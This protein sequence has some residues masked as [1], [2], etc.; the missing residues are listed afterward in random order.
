MRSKKPGSHAPGPSRYVYPGQVNSVALNSRAKITQAMDETRQ[1][2]RE[3]KTD[4]EEHDVA[5][6]LEALRDERRRHEQIIQKDK[7][8][9]LENKRAA[10]FMRMGGQ[11]PPPPL[12]EL[13]SLFDSD[14][15][16]ADE[17]VIV[18]KSAADCDVAGKPRK[19]KLL[20]RKP[21][22]RLDSRDKRTASEFD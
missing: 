6:T 20:L 22:F 4:E 3:A 14:V 17:G 16:E 12:G 18:V 7:K 2:S 9:R 5:L 8:T 13:G 21:G 15:T 10:R 1:K 19:K 11:T